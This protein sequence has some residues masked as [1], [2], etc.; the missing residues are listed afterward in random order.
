MGHR[1]MWVVAY[2]VVLVAVAYGGPATRPADE[3]ARQRAVA[4]DLYKRAGLLFKGGPTNDS[5]AVEYLRKAAEMGHVDAQYDLGV[6]YAYGGGVARDDAI[7][8]KWLILAAEQGHLDAQMQVV[9]IFEQ[10]MGVS[11]DPEKAVE[12]LRK[13]AA[14]EN[15]EAQRRLAIMYYMGRGTPQNAKQAAWWFRKAAENGNVDAQFMLATMYDHGIG[16]EVDPALSAEWYRKAAERGS[17][18]VTYARLFLQH[19]REYPKTR[20]TAYYWVNISAGFRNR[21]RAIRDEMRP[22]DSRGNCRSTELCR[23]YSQRAK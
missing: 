18:E 19:G 11:R 15:A 22:A 13:A 3:D 1:V 5:E 6:R 8:A 23:E 2:L 4:D 21:W 7:A 12:W 14:Q 20:V 9:A 10:G 17:A 16:V